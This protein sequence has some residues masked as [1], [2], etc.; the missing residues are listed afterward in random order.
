MPYLLLESLTDFLVLVRIRSH[1]LNENQERMT[2][3]ERGE[4]LPLDGEGLEPIVLPWKCPEGHAMELCD[5]YNN[6]TKFQFS[7]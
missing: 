5:E 2:L 6:C 7:T 1:P 4:L 3:L